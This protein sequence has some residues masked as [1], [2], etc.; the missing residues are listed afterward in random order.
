MHILVK[1][2]G[3]KLSFINRKRLT[4]EYKTTL[5]T[6][7]IS[8]DE[9]I[10]TDEYIKKNNVVITSFLNALAKECS[11]TSLSFQD[12][13]IANIFT[14]IIPKIKGI[15]LIIFESDEVLS[16]K[17]CEKLIKCP[18]LEKVI[19]NYIPAY[20]FEMLDKYNIIPTSRDEILFTSNFMQENSL[21]NYS[22]IY[23]KYEISLSF[24][25]SIE[26]FEDFTTF[27]KINKNL[28]VI[29]INEPNRFNLEE[30]INTLKI[31]HK[32]KIKILIHG[33]VHDKEVIEYLKKNNKNIKRKYK[34]YLKLKYSDEYIKANIAKQT[35]NNIL[36]MCAY[37]IIVIIA[38]CLGLVLVD[39]YKSMMKVAKITE[40]IHK[41]IEATDT[42]T[43]K[44]NLEKEN[45]GK[46]VINDMVAATTVINSDTVAWLKVNN[47]NIDYPI[48]QT[49]NNS[50]Y[51]N[52][53]INKERDPNGWLFMDSD[54]NH[55]LSDDNTIIYGHNR[56]VNGVMFG[57]LNK[58]L[59]ASWYTNPENQIIELDTLYGSYKFKI[60]SIYIVPTTTDYIQT[61]YY[62]DEDKVN[63]LSTITSRS[64]YNFNVPLDK[65][66]K[67][68]T[69]STCQNDAEKLVVHAVLIDE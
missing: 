56:F 62:N 21:N 61:R 25:L 7:L 31:F 60:F 43:I 45:G 20:M 52:Y 5:N 15:K 10:F 55:D 34:I 68:L 9:L 33:D 38:M 24:P 58:A 3:N 8:N 26:D 23:Y 12:M 30:V 47:T 69:L 41:I 54:N 17:V 65:D 29:H 40:D 22:S 48:L 50:Y 36:R 67:I 11:I 27:C 19:A 35:N 63:F 1:A 4:K 18:S 16:Y 13:D 66:S 28:K 37:F 32:S 49:D 14:N 53:N 46:P 57:T 51:L 59:W 42:T 2:S 39:N 6:N 64:I 44:E